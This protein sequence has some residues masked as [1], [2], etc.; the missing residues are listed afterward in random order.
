MC[1]ICKDVLFDY[2]G[3]P[4]T[5]LECPFLAI[6]YCGICSARGHFHTQCPDATVQRSRKPEY[7]EQL[8]PPS[9]KERYCI[10]GSCTPLPS[11]EPLAA[12]VPPSMWE[13]PRKAEAVKDFLEKRKVLVTNLRLKIRS[14][15]KEHNE[16]VLL[17]LAESQRSIVVWTKSGKQTEKDEDNTEKTEASQGGPQAQSKVPPKKNTKKSTVTAA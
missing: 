4:H 15:D 16:R 11:C 8:I 5:S 14:N 12:K 6:A 3:K 9:L 7:L 13:V 17:K 1:E 10:Q 2:R